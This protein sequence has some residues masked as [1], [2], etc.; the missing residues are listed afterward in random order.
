ME[1]E[2]Y[3]YRKEAMGRNF[4]VPARTLIAVKLLKLK[5]KK[6]KNRKIP[7]GEELLDPLK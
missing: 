2:Y 5:L 3:S 7:A 6:K 1:F 4:F